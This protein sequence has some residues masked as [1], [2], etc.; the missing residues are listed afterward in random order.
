MISLRNGL[1]NRVIEE[2]NTIM[3]Y[4]YSDS[5]IV[6]FIGHCELRFSILLNIMI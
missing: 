2:T 3:N 1:M 4:L 5:F 6:G